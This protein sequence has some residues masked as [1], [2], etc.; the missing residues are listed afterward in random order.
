ML[1]RDCVRK[2]FIIAVS[3]LLCLAAANLFAEEVGNKNGPTAESSDS[4]RG[5]KV[6]AEAGG[7]VLSLSE[8]NKSL[9][10]LE[11]QAKEELTLEKKKALV[12]NWILTRV[13]AAEALKRGFA[14]RDDV[15]SRLAKSRAKILA[16]ELLREELTKITTTEQDISDYY[17]SHRDVFT[18][19]QTVHLGVITLRTQAAAAA[20]LKRL[21]GGED[22]AKVAKSVS[23]DKYKEAGGDAGIIGKSEK[24]PEYVGAAFYLQEGSLSDVIPCEEGYCILKAMSKSAPKTLTFSELSPKLKAMIEKHAL[25]EKRAR[26]ISQLQTELEKKVGVSRNLA[27]LGQ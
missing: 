8:F 12:E 3:M 18:I 19:P 6:L 17:E 25:K 5:E 27:L 7:E 26:A 1:F 22:F 2:A 21:T 10:L 14:E 9:E 11:L 20:V 16:E 4:E 15:K 24:L 23:I 13:L